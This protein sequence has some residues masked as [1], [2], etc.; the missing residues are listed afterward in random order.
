MENPITTESL[1]PKSAK[2]PP[3]KKR[4]HR[5]LNI[6]L[7]FL[8]PD[9]ILDIAYCMY[10]LL[11]SDNE[12]DHDSAIHQ[13]AE[14][15]VEKFRKLYLEYNDL[16][17]PEGQFIFSLQQIVVSLSRGINRRK[18]TYRD[19]IAVA[20][21]KKERQVREINGG[22]FRVWL[23]RAGWRVLVLGGSGFFLARLILPGLHLGENH[24]PTIASLTIA[25][26]TVLI[27]SFIKS[28]WM[29]FCINKIFSSYDTALSKA[30]RAY[31]RGVLGEY[32][33]SKTDAGRFWKLYTGKDPQEWL[34]FDAILQQE[35]LLD[36]PSANK[37]KA[38]LWREVGLIFN[39]FRLIRAVARSW[40]RIRSGRT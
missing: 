2:P 30:E 39:R 17:T 40:R 35:S 4:L 23:L 28:L 38:K 1:T 18:N 6:G 34:G 5:K 9:R 25:I 27:G 26:G 14:N 33:R 10:V 8:T 32:T 15:L 13:T 31:T 24:S 12:N 22:T 36:G 37:Q 19:Q 7:A 29:S 21:E 16:K 11:N 3:K 20:K